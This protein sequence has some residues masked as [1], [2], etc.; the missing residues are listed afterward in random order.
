M[1]SSYTNP[2]Y[3]YSHS[4]DQD[5]AAPVH[6][7]V[8]IVGGGPAGLAAAMDLALQGLK[9]VVLDD[10]NTVS[11]G[12]RAI[13]LAKRT[14]EICDRY[15]CGQPMLD[16]GVTW[17]LG[18]VYFKEEQIYEFNL[19]P[20]Q[21]HKVPAFINL[22]QYYM[23]E[24]MVNRCMEMPEI[25]LRWLH[26]VTRV[27][28][29]DSGAAI[30]V[31]TRDGDYDLT[32]DYLLVADGANSPIRDSLGLESKGQVFEDR[33][34]I[35][36]IIMKADFPAERRFWFDAPFH[37]GQSTLLHKQADNV[38]RI[39]FQLGWDADPEE[40]KKIENIRPRVEAMLGKEMEWELEWASVYT[41]R[42]R[43]MDSFIHHRVFFIGDA[44]H[45]VSPFGARGANG[46]LQSVENLGWKLAAVMRGRAPAALL[47]TYDT[48]RQHGARENILH[49]TRATDFMTPKNHITR[50]FRDTVLDMS[51][52]YPF[53]RALV[54]SGRLSKPC[55]YEQTPLS[56]PDTDE[57]AGA[58][59]PGSACVDAPVSG[60]NHSGWLLN[61]LGNHFSVLLKGDFDA[62][63]ITALETMAA[64]LRAK[65]DLVEIIRIDAPTAG[66]A[67]TIHLADDRGVLATRY[68]L[69]AGAVYL[70]RPDQHVAA[71]WRQLDPGAIEA[72]LKRAMGY[73][74]AVEQ[75]A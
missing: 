38:W 56:T 58:M 52:H 6:H 29:D 4:P 71:R 31:H 75:A 8:I 57:F 19:L 37:P 39:D 1:P 10:N 68:D 65:G 74:L 41:F 12:S 11:V 18:K 49:S 9:T 70:I 47:Q 25:D 7:P 16:K 64:Q 67:G 34:L 62:R 46:A 45:Q 42:C 44:A 51:R 14:L 50:V 59:R 36:D 73:D 5:A 69:Q 27:S 30:T 63:K 26:K 72:A 60:G 61:H 22:Q 54:N 20:E 2:E 21:D 66:G 43:K 28:T 53:A 33:F 15:G 40:E 24:Y 35:A 3:P 13:C 32:C 48:E 23:E 55:T 17:H